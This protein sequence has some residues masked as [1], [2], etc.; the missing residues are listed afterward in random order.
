MVEFGGVLSGKCNELEEGWVRRRPVHSINAVF[1][2]TVSGRAPVESR[3][4]CVVWTFGNLGF[5]A[6]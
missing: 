2:S 5:A 3:G 6:F 4:C 1:F